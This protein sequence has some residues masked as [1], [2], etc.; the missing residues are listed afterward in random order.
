MAR[1]A[2]LPIFQKGYDLIIRFFQETRNFPREHKFTLGQKIK[3]TGLELLDW[4]IMAN[5]ERDKRPALKEINLRVERLR[6]YTRL[7]Y[8]LKVIGIKKY[9]VLSKYIDE[10]G[11][12]V[13]GWMKSI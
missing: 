2:H 1:Y 8:D 10:I 3:D 5:L 4:I 13:G 12:M 6:I 9:E 11:K 7:S